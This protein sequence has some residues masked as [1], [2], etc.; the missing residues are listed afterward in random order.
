MGVLDNDQ[1]VLDDIL[2][3]HK[4]RVDVLEPIELRL[5]DPADDAGVVWRELYGLVC[6]LRREVGQVLL[7]LQPK[8]NM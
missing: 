8:K 4:K 2:C 3:R 5:V 6:E 7:V 1:D